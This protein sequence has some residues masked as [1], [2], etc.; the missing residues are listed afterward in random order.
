MSS[1]LPESAVVGGTEAAGMESSGEGAA[2]GLAV[3]ST[4]VS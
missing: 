1:V 4:S 2:E 3:P